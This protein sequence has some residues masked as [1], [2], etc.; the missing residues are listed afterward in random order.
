MVV[1]TKIRMEEQEGIIVK[2]VKKRKRKKK[3]PNGWLVMVVAR[4][5]SHLHNPL[6]THPTTLN[7]TTQ[8]QF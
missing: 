8:T 6:F 1:T 2:I 3:R 5:E 7:K 4:Y